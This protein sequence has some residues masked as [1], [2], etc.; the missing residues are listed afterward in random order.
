M[1]L[2]G[3]FSDAQLLRVHRQGLTLCK[4]YQL[5]SNAIVSFRNGGKSYLVV[6]LAKQAGKCLGDEAVASSTVRYWHADYVNGSGRLQPD[7]RGHHTRELLVLEEDV[8]SKFVKW[9]L[10]QAKA[11]DLSVDS[12]RDYLNNELLNSLEACVGRPPSA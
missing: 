10:K 5:L 12:A 1:C 9:S 6:E 4:Y 2:S 7:E 11:D 8:H 3:D